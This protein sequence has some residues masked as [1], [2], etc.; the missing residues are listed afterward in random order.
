MVPKLKPVLPWPSWLWCIC[1]KHL[2]IGEL[3]V[4]PSW[5]PGTSLSVVDIGKEGEGARWMQKPA[6]VECAGTGFLG[7]RSLCAVM[8]LGDI[9]LGV[10]SRSLVASKAKCVHIEERLMV[11][12]VEQWWWSWDLSPAEQ[13]PCSPPR[14]EQVEMRSP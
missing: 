11:S 3:K 14:Q 8:S 9:G 5:G 1:G 2:P 10:F 4:S 12:E 13:N 6:V 7:G